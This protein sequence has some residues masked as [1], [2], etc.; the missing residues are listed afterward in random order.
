MEKEK[1]D[2]PTDLQDENLAFEIKETPPTDSPVA[3]LPSGRQLIS[4]SNFEP[5]ADG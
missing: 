5:D 1:K 4:M 3:A 2:P